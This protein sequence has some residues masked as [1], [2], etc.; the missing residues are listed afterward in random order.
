VRLRTASLGL[1]DRSAIP[2]SVPGPD[3]L[4]ATGQR[5]CPRVRR[6]AQPAHP[7]NTA[8]GRALL[9]A[10]T[11]SSVMWIDRSTSLRF[12]CGATAARSRTP[13]HALFGTSLASLCS[14]LAYTSTP[15]HI[16]KL[17]PHI[18]CPTQSAAPIGLCVV[19]SS[20]IACAV[21]SERSTLSPGKRLYHH[22]SSSSHDASPHP[23][24]ERQKIH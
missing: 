2:A 22:R 14:T 23:Q 6:R 4:S 18:L 19:R 7:L 21:L 9:P 20:P 11:H 16:Y 5:A 1:R 24:G 13:R 12:P 10:H 3:W 8:A 15:S 17:Y